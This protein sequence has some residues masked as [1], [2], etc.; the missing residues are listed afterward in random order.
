VNGGLG[1]CSLGETSLDEQLALR[2]PWGGG[3]G[4]GGG[5]G[6]GGGG[7]GG[8]G[9]GGSRGLGGGG[10]GGGGGVVAPFAPSYFIKKRNPSQL[11]KEV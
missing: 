2:V 3:W 4:V 10:W 1:G 9:G 8:G 5:G 6:G 11:R 7:C